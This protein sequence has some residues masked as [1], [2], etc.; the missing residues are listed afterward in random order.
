[1]LHETFEVG[2][3]FT[4]PE[5]RDSRWDRWDIR[6]MMVENGRKGTCIKLENMIGSMIFSEYTAEKGQRQVGTLQDLAV[7]KFKCNIGSDVQP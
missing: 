7:L 4:K 2:F 3:G 1:M 5:T 6:W